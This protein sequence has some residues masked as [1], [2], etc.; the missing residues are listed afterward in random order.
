MTSDI[1][2]K[3]YNFSLDN[4]SK[5]I[6]NESMK[7]HTSFKIGGPADLFIEPSSVSFL[8][9]LIKEIRKNETPYWVIGNGSN[10]LVSD[11]GLRGIVIHISSSLSDMRLEEN[12]ITCEA[13]ASLKKLCMF[14]LDNGL[15]GLEF[16]YGI[17][18]SVGGAA[19]MN[20][21]AYGGEMKDVLISCSHID[22]SGDIGSLSNDELNLSY[23]HSAYSTNKYIIASLTLSLKRGDKDDIKQRMNELMNRRKDKQPLDFPSAGS[24]FK[25]PPD[26]FAGA[27]IEKCGLK[28]KSIGGAQVSEKHAGFIINR[29]GATCVDILQLIE[30]IQNVVYK[31]CDILLSPE[32]K[33]IG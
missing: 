29:G 25:R 18:G 19:F 15:S 9:E 14:A 22:H 23:R 27:L 1:I 33:V 6:K 8:C 20:A 4:G 16:A 31:E 2:D 32:L 3:I 5:A 12:I 30:L 11:K 10:L 24:V 7:N 17:P 21:G 28:G 26:N 13:G